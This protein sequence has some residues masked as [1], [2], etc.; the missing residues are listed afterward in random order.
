MASAS[1][2]TIDEGSDSQQNDNTNSP[3][4]ET[5]AK[6]SAVAP[7]ATRS[8]YLVTYSLANLEKFPA[9][10]EFAKAIIASFTQG[11]AR[12]LQWC[13][14]VE[15]HRDSGKHY[16]MALKLNKV[17]RWLPSKRYVSEQ[18]GISVH[19]SNIH[20][21]YYS[22]WR[23]VTKSDEAYAE[24]DGKKNVR[25]KA[26]VKRVTKDKKKAKGVGK[27]KKKR[28][29][30]LDVSNIILNKNIRTENELLALAQEQREQGK[31]D[32]VAFILNRSPKTLADILT[33]T[34][35][36]KGAGEKISRSKKTRIDL[37]QEASN[38]GCVTGCSGDWLQC[39]NEVLQNNGI[40]IVHLLSLCEKA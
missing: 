26:V 29:T 31:T 10:N 38:S 15:N 18:F 19:Y 33:T 7:S 3:Y 24:S 27:A 22:A 17:Q 28:L 4:S 35:Q 1:T 25:G 2:E 5:S 30:P 32:L 39:A 23:Y 37:L 13:C 14:S 36:M 6:G 34:W 20:H 12:V 40:S 9:R 16:H 8:V 11:S 21:D